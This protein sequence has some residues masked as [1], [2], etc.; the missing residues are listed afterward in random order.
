MRRSGRFL[1][2]SLLV[3][4]LAV[5][6]GIFVC[7][8]PPTK[9]DGDARA[10]AGR[11]L[12]ALKKGD[13]GA[14]FSMT[15]V[16]IDT[17]RS[18]TAFEEASFV[19]ACRAGKRLVEYDLSWFYGLRV[20]NVGHVSARL[21]YADGSEERSTLKVAAGG[22]YTSVRMITLAPQGG[23]V[24][25]PRI[26]GVP[27]A[28]EQSGCPVAC[29]LEPTNVWVFSGHH[30]LS[31]AGS[32]WTEPAT[33]PLAADAT[34]VEV[35]PVFTA[36]AK[37][38]AGRAVRQ[39]KPDCLRPDFC[40]FTPCKGNDGSWPAPKSM[41][42]L[43]EARPERMGIIFQPNTWEVE[44]PAKATCPKGPAAAVDVHLDFG[45]SGDPVVDYVFPAR[46]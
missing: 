14:A 2:W 33:Q 36:A 34:S 15:R 6:A 45:L 39:W 26:D 8:R 12:D 37:E 44:V 28:R 1:R 46:R 41:T 43:G 10:V 9:K 32:R 25:D 16:A 31:V 40:G 18:A 27:V 35:P 13:C 11:Y 5:V 29:M 38:A 20:G 7:S 30:T 24:L 4:V 3:V 19:A 42:V 17:G 23:P 22:L 21:R